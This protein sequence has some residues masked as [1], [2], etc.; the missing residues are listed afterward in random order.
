MAAKTIENYNAG[1]LGTDHKYYH[2]QN[3]C[4][5]S[6]I[7]DPMTKLRIGHLSTMY[8]TSFILMG[9]DW[10]EKTGIEAEW[11]LFGGGPA[12]V[13]ALENG[14]LDVGYIGLPPTMIGIDREVDIKCIAGGHVEGT[15]M[16]AAKNF[17]TFEECHNNKI[18]FFEQFKGSTIAC[19]PEGS[20]HDVIIRN[21]LKEV[22]LEKVI[23][24]KNYEWADMI[25]ED[26]ADEIIKIAVGT[27]SLAIVTE[28]YS[29]AKIVMRPE[30][31]WP[32]NPSYGIIATGDMIK[33]SPE[34]LL[35]FI[36]LHDD[37][38][39]FMNKNTKEAAEIVARTIEVIDADFVY[40][41]YKISPKYSAAISEEYIDSTMRFVNVLKS[42]GYISKELEITDIFDLRFVE[43]LIDQ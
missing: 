22:G 11:K 30:K 2:E 28:K 39:V 19:P 4:T 25:A 43:E 3:S 5:S 40:Q 38:C 20:I 12:I 42:L 8:H 10:L 15:V 16:V 27:P 18:T 9:M 36:E 23:P 13:N 17:L 37:A 14:E 31:L 29:N 26:M 32:F 6:F 7:G 21:E 41:M 35:R 1:I 33:N 24:I 34:V